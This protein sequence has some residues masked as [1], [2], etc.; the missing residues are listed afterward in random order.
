MG[1]LSFPG[2]PVATTFPLR[3]SDEGSRV[4]RAAA[5]S[6]SMEGSMNGVPSPR[7]PGQYAAERHRRGLRSFRRRFYRQMLWAFAL[8]VLVELLVALWV[9]SSVGWLLFAFLTGA[10]FGSFVM[11]RDFAPDHVRRWGDGA[12][13][14]QQTA[15]AL[16]PLAERGWNVRHDV[17][18]ARGGNIDHV[19]E[20]PA[21]RW[22]VLETKT[23]R[24]EI[25][26]EKGLLTST[27]VDD[28]DQVYRH[29]KLRHF[30]LDRARLLQSRRGRG[31]V[32]AVVVVWGEF[33]QRCLKDG[34]VVFVH[35]D[36]LATWLRE[37]PS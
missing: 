36:E 27:Q 18:L 33:P 23:L 3:H 29:N 8:V 25:R 34:Q 19:V 20:S 17:E 37:Q 4:A 6:S 22:F 30:V 15:K 2:S 7:R 13:G 10:S 11:A 24:G 28:P 16:T 21:G 5:I 9:D 1:L 26:V 14:E 35:G 12:W 31:W 32:Q